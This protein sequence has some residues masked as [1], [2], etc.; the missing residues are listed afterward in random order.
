[1]VINQEV[2]DGLSSADFVDLTTSPFTYETVPLLSEGTHNIA[3]GL[4]NN[5]RV[6]FI[7]ST[8]DMRPQA[9]IWSPGDEA[10][11]PVGD[12]PDLGLDLLRI[13]SRNGRYAVGTRV[14]GDRPQDAIVTILP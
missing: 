12:D 14:H 6:L 9:A 8:G 10:R 11:S 2:D 13:L 5:D 4:G 1:M 7:G 3:L